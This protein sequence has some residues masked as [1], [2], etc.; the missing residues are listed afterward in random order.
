MD[1]FELTNLNQ[2]GPETH[3]YWIKEDKGLI[4]AHDGWLG[5]SYVILAMGH[6]EFGGY[7]IAR[8][9]TSI[10]LTAGI[11]LHD[12]WLNNLSR[13]KKTFCFNKLAIKLLEFIHHPVAMYN[14]RL[15]HN[16]CML[17][18]QDDYQFYLIW[19]NNPSLS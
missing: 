17:I 14:P 1:A 7:A 4:C 10:W 15:H 3:K 18:V 16:S 12:G 11:T 2:F 8:T 9:L 6:F 13:L 5:W 19:L